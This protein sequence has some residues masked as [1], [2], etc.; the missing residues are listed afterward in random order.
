MIRNLLIRGM[1]AGLVVGLVGFGFA[2]TFGEP[3]V[4]RAIAFEEQHD[5]RTIMRKPAPMRRKA[6]PR[7]ITVTMR[8]SS[9][10]IRSRGLVC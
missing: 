1:L 9:A 10:A 5:I 6:R 8:K 2:K 3:S 4:A 7:T